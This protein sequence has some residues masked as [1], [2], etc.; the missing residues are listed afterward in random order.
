MLGSFAAMQGVDIGDG[1][2]PAGGDHRNGQGAGQGGGRRHI[3][4][5]EQPVAVNVGEEDGGDPGIL[6]ALAQIRPASV[7]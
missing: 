1:A 3:H 5:L 4:A 6:E 2:D 7:R